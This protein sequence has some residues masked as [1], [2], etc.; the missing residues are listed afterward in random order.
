MSKHIEV[1]QGSLS[2][3]AL[4]GLVDEFVTR[5]GTDYGEREHTLDDK[6]RGVMR[7]LARGEVSIVFDFESESTTLVTRE[8]LRRLFSSAAHGD[9]EGNDAG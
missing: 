8:E 9:G 4:A 2:E 5:E 1:P 7:Q 3:Q 6:R